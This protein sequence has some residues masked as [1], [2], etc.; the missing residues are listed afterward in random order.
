MIACDSCA[1]VPFESARRRDIDTQGGRNTRDG[2]SE[3]IGEKQGES[4]RSGEAPTSTLFTYSQALPPPSLHFPPLPLLS[5]SGPRPTLPAMTPPDHCRDPTPKPDTPHVGMICPDSEVAVRGFSMPR[6][7]PC[8]TSG[9]RPSTSW[10]R[11]SLDVSCARGIPD[12]CLSN[13]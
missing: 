5:T 2:P 7:S 13:R 12:E 1:E 4:E 11:I 9:Y 6:E 3:R 10:S 8:E